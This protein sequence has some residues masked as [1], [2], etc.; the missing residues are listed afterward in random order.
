MEANAIRLEAPSRF[1]LRPLAIAVRSEAIAIRLEAIAF[2][3]EA[4]A[5]RLEAIA[6]RLEAI[7]IRLEGIAISL[8]AIAFRLEAPAIRLE[9]AIAVRLEAIAIRL[10]GIAIRLEAL[11]VVGWRLSLLGWRS[12]LLGGGRPKTEQRCPHQGAGLY[13]AINFLLL[14]VSRALLSG[15]KTHV[16]RT[17][18]KQVIELLVKH[19]LCTL[20][21]HFVFLSHVT[22]GSP[23]GDTLS[24]SCEASVGTSGSNN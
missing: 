9:E 16:G 3:L 8:E 22:K 21:A 24:L 17:M 6:F 18:C 14:G 2:R 5:I 15:G 4:T 12:L 13:E 19:A 20:F 11:A 23:L 1:G 10:E 7:A